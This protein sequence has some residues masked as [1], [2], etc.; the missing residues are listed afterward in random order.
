MNGLI[1]LLII[2]LGSLIINQI[3]SS[4]TNIEGLAS[5]EESKSDKEKKKLPPPATK[6]KKCDPSVSRKVS[7]NE[8]KNNRDFKTLK[9]GY[10]GLKLKLAL[11]KDKNSEL[12]SQVNAT[13]EEN[14]KTK[15]DMKKNEKQLRQ[16]QIVKSTKTKNIF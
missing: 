1:I 11:M 7:D 14:K 3:I 12:Q 13:E 2:L 6:N 8:A 5:L 16:S 4:F 10:G 9:K 15:K